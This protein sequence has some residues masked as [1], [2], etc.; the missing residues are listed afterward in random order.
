M[1]IVSQYSNILVQ[2][3]PP[4]EIEVAISRANILA[5]NGA[6]VEVVATPGAGRSL[7]FISAVL[8]YDRD[9]ATYGAGGD[10]TIEYNGGDTVSTTIGAADSFG[11]ATDEIFSFMRLNASGGY[12]MPENT[13][14]DITNAAAAFTDPGTAVGVARLQITYKVHS[15]GL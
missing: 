11:S 9:T 3:E 1:T 14:L 6:P 12:T 13:A 15:T 5:M 10:V 2:D 7:E 4:I 8:V